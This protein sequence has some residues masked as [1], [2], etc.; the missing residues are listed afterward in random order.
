MSAATPPAPPSARAADALYQGVDRAGAGYRLLQR[1]GWKEGEGL[2]R[3][4]FGE[5]RGR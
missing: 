4:E 5:E 3:G 2:V 1:M